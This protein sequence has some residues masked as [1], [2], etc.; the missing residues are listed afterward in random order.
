MREPTVPADCGTGSTSVSN[1]AKTVWR[2]YFDTVIDA[3]DT[4]EP[5]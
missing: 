4:I 2:H 1:A 3:L 5:L